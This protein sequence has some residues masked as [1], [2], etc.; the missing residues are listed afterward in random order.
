MPGK[1]YI[2]ATPIGNLGDITIRA[3]E[4]LKQVDLIACEDTRRTIKLLN[5]LE[6]RQKTV[7]FHEHSKLKKID[8]LVEK[9]LAG[10]NIALVTDAGTPGICDPGGQLV[11]KAI[12]NGIEAISIPG[13]SVLTALLS[14]SGSRNEPCLFLGYPPKK[15]RENFWRRIFESAEIG[16]FKTICFYESC[17]R[18][19]KT[20]KFLLDINPDLEL[21]VA[22]ELT[23]KFETI[24]RGDVANVLEQLKNSN[25]KGEFTVLLI[26]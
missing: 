3:I 14:I 16:K 1:L 18:I 23:K 25:I 19:E 9:L 2:V 21:I 13:P 8:F 7:S 17:H 24:I 6:I 5:H 15:G 4:T 26:P 22:R 10:E 12:E 20:L 11:K